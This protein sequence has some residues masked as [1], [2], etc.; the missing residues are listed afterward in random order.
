MYNHWYYDYCHHSGYQCIYGLFLLLYYISLLPL[1]AFVLPF[2]VTLLFLSLLSFFIIV[3]ILYHYDDSCYFLIDWHCDILKCFFNIINAFVCFVVIGHFPMYLWLIGCCFCFFLLF[4]CLLCNVRL[5]IFI[6]VFIYLGTG[7]FFECHTLVLY[8]KFCSIHM[9]THIDACSN[10]TNHAQTRVHTDTHTHSRTHTHTQTC[11]KPE[12]DYD[13]AK[14][15][16][17]ELFFIFIYIYTYV[18]VTLRLML[19][20]YGCPIDASWQIHWCCLIDS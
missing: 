15:D 2:I 1:S 19:Q 5:Y 6:Y 13:C 18:W 3:I 9:C 20:N 17:I 8:S 10:I 14:N 12:H 4:V 7:A 11:R 16:L